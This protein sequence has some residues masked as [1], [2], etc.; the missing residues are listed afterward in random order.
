MYIAIVNDARIIV[1]DD[2]DGDHYVNKRG[3]H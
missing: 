1:S 2:A 3:A